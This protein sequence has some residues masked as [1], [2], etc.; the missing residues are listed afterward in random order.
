M[1]TANFAFFGQ[2]KMATIQ[3]DICIIGAGPSGATASL[4]LAKAGIPHLI[5]DAATFPRDKVCGDGLDLKVFRVL[6]HLDPEITENE[7]FANTN[8][9]QSWGARVIT[10]KGRAVDFVHRPRPG[11]LNKP[12]LFTAKRLHF[13][14]FLVRKIDPR[15]A[16]FRPATKVTDIVRDGEGWRVLAKTSAGADLEIRAKLI[17]AADGDHSVMLR[18]LGERKI[19]RRHYAGTLR[20]YWRGIGGLHP[21]NLIEIYFPPGLPMSYFY[22]FPLPDG[23]ANVGYGMV[24]EV[25]AQHKHNLRELF[26]RLIH[27]DPVMAPRFR[28]AEPLETPI[29]WGIPLASRQRKTFGDGYLLLG[30]AGSLVCPTSGEGIGTGMMSGLI[31]ARFVEHALRLRRF[32]AAVFQNFDREVYRRLRDDIRA[33]NFAMNHTP[34]WLYE[35]SINALIPSGLYQWIFRKSMPGW[36]RTAYERPIEVNV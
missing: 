21:Q 3:T 20:Q 33:Y 1:E 10:P 4:F 29:G 31:A 30:D 19:D 13:D 5:L 7:V 32:D 24:S 23:E 8:F 6:H 35:G 9:L 11:E 2:H 25:A 14:D 22:I 26:A 36:L 34:R 16:D 15:F 18:T 17:L 27:D 28:G 12:P